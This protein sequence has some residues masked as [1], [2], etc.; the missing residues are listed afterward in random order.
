V[1]ATTLATGLLVTAGAVQA[2]NPYA[3]PDDAWISLSG[4][5]DAVSADTF[6]LVALPSSSRGDT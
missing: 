5:L 4:T 3:Q 1:I 6:T 2:I